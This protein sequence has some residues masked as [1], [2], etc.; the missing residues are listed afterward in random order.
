MQTRWLTG[1]TLLFLLLSGC[2]IFIDSS[3]GR[4]LPV[5][6]EGWFRT[7]I[8]Y[9]VS[10]SLSYSFLADG[11]YLLETLT[12]EGE[13]QD[14]DKDS[15]TN[16]GWVLFSGVRGTYSFDPEMMLMTL[17]LSSRYGT[18]GGNQAY[19]WIPQTNAN[20]TVRQVFNAV[21]LEH[22][23]YFNSISS[24]KVLT[25][26]NNGSWAGMYRESYYNG[27]NSLTSFKVTV[28]ISQNSLKAANPNT[29]LYAPDGTLISGT[30]YDYTSRIDSL[31]PDGVSWQPG[32][33][34]TFHVTATADMKRT[35]T[36]STWSAW[37][38]N[39]GWVPGDQEL[40]I[41]TC[42]HM[43]DYMV[44]TPDTSSLLGA[45]LPEGE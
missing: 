33:T 43:G 41:I 2:S 39:S 27:T 8:V 44:V 30:E 32:Q 20:S 38:Y 21:P 29:Y 9:H 34:V 11:R 6:S 5:T 35:Y 15:I 1:L 42:A 19:I 36:P 24:M 18:P 4:L 45:T 22:A 40:N 31:A 26:Q 7:D 25:N 10:S 12:Y 3:N 23:Y 14:K 13:G 28:N 37:G 16:E 17:N